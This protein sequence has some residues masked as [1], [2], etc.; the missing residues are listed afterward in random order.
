MKPILL[1]LSL[2]SFTLINAQTNISGAVYSSE[3]WALSNS[4]YIVSG[5][6]VIFDGVEITIEPGVTVMFDLSASME[7]RGKL[8]AIGTA[9]DSITFTSSLPNPSMNSWNGIN[10]LGTNNQ[11]GGN[12]VTMHYVNGMFASTFIN[13]NLAYNG[14][15]HFEDCYFAYNG[16]VNEDGGS[17]STV[18]EHCV[19][20]ANHQA[21]DWCQFDSRVSQ[22][23][24][25]DNNI[26]LIGIAKVDT[27]YFSG[28]TDYAM[29]PY[30]ITTGCTIEYNNIGVKTGF[31]GV[32][33]TFTNNNVKHNNIGLEIASFFNGT[34]TFSENTICD[35]TTYNLKL[36]SANN[37]DLGLNC[38]CNDDET[39]IQTTIFDGYED[40][41]YGLVSLSPLYSDCETS[42]F[43]ETPNLIPE[44]L[45][46]SFYPNP[47]TE[48]I[49]LKTDNKSAITLNIYDMS[50]RLMA[51][52]IFQHEC[53]M[54]L[55]HLNSG[56]YYF[57]AKSERGSV[58]SGKLIKE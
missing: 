37:A 11:P 51:E 57:A 19:F 1:I 34:Q 3:T 21:L 5:N 17:P 10:V 24:F 46:V 44:D 16:K 32:N 12:Q 38:W 47:F 49:H 7:L 54:Y 26:G 14:P 28:H 13:M 58:Y 43:A 9:T 20:E 45:S 25:Y 48:T 42:L 31:N 8:I 33:H 36:L 4:P 30:G 15:Y 52:K 40:V 41:S 39:Q 2:I 22:S 56:V 18:F 55:S 29:A 23:H 6:L 35:N 53:T 50:G 27:C